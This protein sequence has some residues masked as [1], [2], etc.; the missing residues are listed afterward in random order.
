MKKNIDYKLVKNRIFNKS[1]CVSILVVFIILEL[2]TFYLAEQ[3]KE[4][5]TVNQY[6]L[7]EEESLKDFII[8]LEKNEI[9]IV[10]MN[11]KSK[12]YEFK[13]MVRGTKEEIKKKVEDLV[14]FNINSYNLDVKDELI[15]GTLTISTIS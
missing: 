11:K 12:G 14:D 1:V 8:Q 13:V 15:K 6:I 10:N 9:N 4:K 2:W 3:K 7:K 5:I